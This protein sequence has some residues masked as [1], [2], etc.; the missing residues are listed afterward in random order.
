MVAKLQTHAAE[1]L[2]LATVSPPRCWV[3]VGG[4]SYRESAIACLSAARAA[5]DS[6]DA[7]AGRGGFSPC[8]GDGLDCGSGSGS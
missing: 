8:G 3:A 6:T 1:L 5:A 2:M 7:L 4:G